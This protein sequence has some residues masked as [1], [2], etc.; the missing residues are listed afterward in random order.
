[1]INKVILFIL[2]I[3]LG[4]YFF[5]VSQNWKNPKLMEVL[6]VLV[7]VLITITW[8]IISV[9]Q[10]IKGSFDHQY[11]T[12]FDGKQTLNFI[13]HPVLEKIFRNHTDISAY[14]NKNQEDFNLKS[15][16][17]SV[18]FFSFVILNSFTHKFF[19]KWYYKKKF[20]RMIFKL[21]N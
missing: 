7:G 1:M 5:W 19:A 15:G 13:S 10:T 4:L 9:P 14:I 20:Q 6:P 12:D 11:F 3:V 21:L 2:F 8:S 17:E 16:R 18:E